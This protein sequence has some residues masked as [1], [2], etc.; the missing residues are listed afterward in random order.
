MLSLSL[1]W[2][3]WCAWRGVIEDG[4]VFERDDGQVTPVHQHG[5][6]PPFGV[7]AH[8]RPINIVRHTSL[9]ESI[10]KQG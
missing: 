4:C 2:S 7:R 9:D 3:E 1:P 5:R 10:S 6:T 8:A